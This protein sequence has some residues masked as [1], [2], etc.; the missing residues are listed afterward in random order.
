MVPNSSIK[1]TLTRAM[2]NNN[3]T[4]VITLLQKVI[5]Y[6]KI[7][8]VVYSTMQSSFGLLTNETIQV[9][10]LGIPESNGWPTKKDFVQGLL[11]SNPN[12]LKNR[13]VL[14]RTLIHLPE[15]NYIIC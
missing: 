4:S 13:P 15:N 11:T 12:I 6:H 2:E 1:E 8:P 9:Q 14:Q 7:A 10:I 3:E 5:H